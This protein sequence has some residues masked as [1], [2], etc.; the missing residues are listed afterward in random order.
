[1]KQWLAEFA[2]IFT[3]ALFEKWLGN[4]KKVKSNSTIDLVGEGIKTALV[5]LKILK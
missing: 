1:M 5:K 4:T 2:A 3:Y